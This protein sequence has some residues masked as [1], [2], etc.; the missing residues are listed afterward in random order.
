MKPKFEKRVLFFF[1]YSS[2]TFI[3]R[4]NICCYGLMINLLFFHKPCIIILSNIIYI[5]IK[6]HNIHNFWRS[7]FVLYIPWNCKINNLNVNWWCSE[8]NTRNK[9]HII[10]LFTFSITRFTYYYYYYFLCS[11]W[12]IWHLSGFV[13][14][15]KRRVCQDTVIFH[16]Y[17]YLNG[18]ICK[19]NERILSVKRSWSFLK[20]MKL[21][22]KYI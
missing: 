14:L 2:F 16:I 1:F 5:Y 21:K 7:K 17:F 15:L 11:T 4:F 20:I 3:C 13:S 8:D 9:R 6:V 19:S 22:I 18:E 10:N 12:R